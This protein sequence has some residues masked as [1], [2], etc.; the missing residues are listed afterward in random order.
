MKQNLLSYVCLIGLAQVFKHEFDLRPLLRT[1]LL[2]VQTSDWVS[3]PPS[4]PEHRRRGAVRG[5]RHCR[6]HVPGHLR[7]CGPLRLP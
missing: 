4:G 7:Y 6:H 3:V 1:L 5:H 2:C